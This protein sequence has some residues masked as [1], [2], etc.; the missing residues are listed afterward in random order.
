MEPLPREVLTVSD[1]RAP[2]RR[3][4]WSPGGV[5]IGLALLATVGLAASLAVPRSGGA[6]ATASPT[7]DLS[8]VVQ[9]GAVTYTFG[10][11]RTV[12]GISRTEMRETDELTSVDLGVFANGSSGYAMLC[13]AAGTRA[14][15]RFVFGRIDGTATYSGPAATG[16]SAD[17]GT[18]LFVLDPGA[19]WARLDVKSAGGA[20]G[21]GQD[22][23]V[24]LAA[25]RGP[26]G[27]RVTE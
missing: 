10:L 23:F 7:P 24:E 6:G 27:C 19:P 14:E 9:V 25:Q 8:H 22:P 4:W 20:I 3:S 26:A 12:M 11:D 1:L 18:F 13:P 15:E 21:I 5:V 17:D 16:H 2:D